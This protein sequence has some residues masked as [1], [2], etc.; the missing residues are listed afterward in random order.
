MSERTLFQNKDHWWLYGGLVSEWGRHLVTVPGS[1]LFHGMCIRERSSARHP[2]LLVVTDDGHQHRLSARGHHVPKGLKS[3]IID[4]SQ[5]GGA[6]KP[7]EHVW[8]S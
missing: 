1:P 6:I 7:A 4:L 3:K 2:A 5:L 8:A